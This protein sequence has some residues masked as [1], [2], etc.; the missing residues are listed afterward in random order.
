MDSQRKLV[1][2]AHWPLGGLATF[3]NEPHSRLGK[4]WDLAPITG[5]ERF[6]PSSPLK[7]LALTTL[8]IRQRSLPFFSPGYFPPVAWKGPVACTVHDLF[9]LDPALIDHRA[10][11]TFYR[12]VIA[13]LVRRCELVFTVS[14]ESAGLIESMLRVPRDRIRVVG[15]GVASSFF[16]AGRN[17]PSDRRAPGTERPAELVYVG[18]WLPPKRMSLC[19]DGLATTSPDLD[20]HVSLPPNPPADILQRVSGLRPNIKVEFRSGHLDQGDVA[21]LMA[22]A[23]GLLLLSRA[24][25]FGLTPLEAQA[26]QTAVLVSEFDGARLRYGPGAA[27]VSAEPAPAEIGD[28][29]SALILDDARRHRAIADGT[30]NAAAFTWT[31]VASR[32]HAGLVEL[33]R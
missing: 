8:G 3:T 25:G 23:D 22:G 12:A 28:A 1:V 5:T 29:L 13:P 31:S 14:D 21:R 32:I 16:E 24:E 9:Y 17:T 20:L 15:D 33:A 27:Y 18:N 4:Q 26:A 6:S 19:I 11:R 10:K 2:D 7:P 30:A